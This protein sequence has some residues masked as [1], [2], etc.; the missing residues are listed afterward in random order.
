LVRSRINV[1]GAS[2]LNGILVEQGIESCPTAFL[3]TLIPQ[4]EDGILEHICIKD[5]LSKC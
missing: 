2:A 4:S 1:C 5:K 3:Y